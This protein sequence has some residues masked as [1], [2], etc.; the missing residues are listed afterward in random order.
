MPLFLQ[1]F[2]PAGD[3]SSSHDA[4]PIIIK[5]QK[6]F[7]AHSQPSCQVRKSTHSSKYYSKLMVYR[8]HLRSGL[9][10]KDLKHG[11]F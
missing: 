11:I 7:K 2:N 4:V 6:M 8:L 9:Y 10:T 5:E 3:A 1:H